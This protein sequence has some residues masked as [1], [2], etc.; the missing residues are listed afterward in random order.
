MTIQEL[1]EKHGL[2]V[3]IRADKQGWP[4]FTVHT[5]TEHGW[6]ADTIDGKDQYVSNE[7]HLNDYV[8]ATK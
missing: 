2:P 6:L 4:E 8:L 5:K 3:T 1:I 7:P